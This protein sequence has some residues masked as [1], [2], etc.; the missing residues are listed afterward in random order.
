MKTAIV[1]AQITSVEDKITGNLSFKQM[2]LLITP[3]FISAAIFAF[4]PPFGK[5]HIYK[6]C[7]SSLIAFVSILLAVRIKKMI[8]LD[9]IVILARYS[10]RPQFYIYNKNNV[11]GRKIEKTN[12]TA[13]VE[14]T[15]EPIQETVIRQFSHNTIDEMTFE[16]KLGNPA[17]NMHFTFSKKGGLRVHI[18]EIK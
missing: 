8:I 1:P 7:I 17:A 3:V 2:V 15:P 5:L 6:I 16:D 9:W 10:A 12:N 14:L 11:T 13:P 18:K 4:L